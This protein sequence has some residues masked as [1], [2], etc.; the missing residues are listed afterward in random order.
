[1]DWRN[2][3]SELISPFDLLTWLLILAICLFVSRIVKLSRSSHSHSHNPTL[4]DIS[5]SMF[6]SILD[7]ASSLFDTHKETTKCSFCWCVSCIPLTWLL[8]STLYKGENVSRLTAEPPLIKFDTFKLLEEYH[9]TVYSVRFNLK[10]YENYYNLGRLA[11]L[12]QQYGSVITHEALPIV[13]QLWHGIM[14]WLRP[15]NI[16]ELSLN[17]L[18][19][20]IPPQMWKYI[21]VCLQC[22]LTMVKDLMK[23]YLQF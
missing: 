3:L 4:L 19:D 2:Q 14:E 11:K 15:F 9:F 7:Q 10:T 20:E 6:W 13:S 8:L 22:C 5:F 17:F 1:M 12:H 23:R 16:L 18:K 21:N